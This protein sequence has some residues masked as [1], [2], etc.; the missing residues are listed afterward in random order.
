MPYVSLINKDIGIKTEDVGVGTRE[1]TRGVVGELKLCAHG[2][3]EGDNT[4][5]KTIKGHSSWILRF[6]LKIFSLAPFS[7]FVFDSS[8][9]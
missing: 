9:R 7:Y 3:G 2:S 8:G 1:D 4:L 6:K 5:Q